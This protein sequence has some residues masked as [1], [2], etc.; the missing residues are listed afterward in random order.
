MEDFG[1]FGDHIRG[2]LG[3]SVSSDRIAGAHY[4]A[5]L[6]FPLRML[7]LYNSQPKVFWLTSV[8]HDHSKQERYIPSRRQ[9]P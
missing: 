3:N 8:G 1:F 6:T 5:L 4:G 9:T 7:A 2:V